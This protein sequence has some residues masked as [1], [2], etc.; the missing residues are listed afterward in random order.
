[1][2]ETVL[3]YTTW[4][5]LTDAEQAGR[6]LV[7]AKLCACVNILPAM[8]SIYA[9]RGAVERA[10]E[11]VMILKTGRDRLDALMEAVRA[12]HPYDTPAILE[13]PV[14]LVDPRYGAWITAE[15]T[16]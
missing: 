7:E 13:L 1:M 6:A 2:Q 8:V 4:P 14:G 11:V 9:W 16:P 12:A 10:E 5:R 15:T 3:V